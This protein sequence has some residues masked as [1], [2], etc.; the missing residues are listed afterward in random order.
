MDVH[1]IV[2]KLNNAWAVYKKGLS[3]PLT[4]N[5]TA[6]DAQDYAWQKLTDYSDQG[7]DVRITID[8]RDE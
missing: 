8:T 7:F 6:K 2:K 4:F 5:R 3:A 1:L